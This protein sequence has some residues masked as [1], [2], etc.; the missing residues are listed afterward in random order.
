[1]S[2]KI[3][4]IVVLI[5]FRNALAFI[6]DCVNS[7]FNQIYPIYEIYLLDDASTDNTL[8]EIDLELPCLH[9]VRNEKRVWAMENIYHPLVNLP[10]A[11]EDIIIIIDGDD[12]LFGEYTFQ[13]INAKYNEKQV[14]I[15]YG[16]YITN[17]GMPGNFAPYTEL[18]FQNIRKARWK[19]PHLR[20][21]KYKLFRQFRSVDPLA[22]SFKYDDGCF[23]KS[24]TD[25]AL[26]FSLFEIAGHQ[27]TYCFPN[28]LYCYRVHYGN[29][30]A[31]EEGKRLQL[32]AEYY[33][34]GKTSLN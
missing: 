1:M 18:E 27:A 31:S 13:M 17:F 15:T 2:E 20:T 28:V 14:L 21:F 34:R 4:K 5:P 10:L 33:V 26:M 3:H 16:Q 32:E 11:D 24:A 9:V 19:A 30:H 8:N 29:T 12:S 6:V 23:L 25:M 7:V 22:K